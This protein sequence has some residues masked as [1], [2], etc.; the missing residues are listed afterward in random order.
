MNKK[1]NLIINLWENQEITQLNNSNKIKNF[2]KGITQEK[3]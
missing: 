3:V 1:E 2:Q